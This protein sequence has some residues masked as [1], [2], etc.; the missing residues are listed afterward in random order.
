VSEKLY[1]TL[2]KVL[3]ISPNIDPFSLD[4]YTEAIKHIKDII[5]LGCLSWHLERTK[6][7]P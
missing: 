2:Q 6:G 4:W 5:P 3:R 1:E 7:K